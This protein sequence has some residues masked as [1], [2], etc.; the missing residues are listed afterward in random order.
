MDAPLQIQYMRVEDLKKSARFTMAISPEDDRDLET[1][2]LAIGQ[3]KSNVIVML[4]RSFVQ[5]MKEEGSVVL[6][7][8]LKTPSEIY[9]AKIPGAKASVSALRVAESRGRYKARGEKD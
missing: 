9:N 2:A 7:F 4:I 8:R 3:S 1:C 5:A 6:P